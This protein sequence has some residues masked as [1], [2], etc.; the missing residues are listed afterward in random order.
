M[1]KNH[2]GHITIDEFIR[3][4]LEADELLRKKIETAKQNIDYYKRQYEDNLKK[5]QET[6]YSE[7]LNSYGIMDG[8]FVNATIVAA[9]NLKSAGIT[10][11]VSAYVEVSLDDDQNVKTKVVHNNPNPSWNEKLTL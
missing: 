5:S 7:K 9:R 2:D 11:I 10:G 8:S 3:V 6:R 4:Y 1:D